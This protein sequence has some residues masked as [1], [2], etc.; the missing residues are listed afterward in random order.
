MLNIRNK[1]EV[2]CF[3]CEL[4]REIRQGAAGPGP[5]GPAVDRGPH[6]SGGRT[7]PSDPL[8]SSSSCCSTSFPSGLF[9][10]CGT[11]HTAVQIASRSPT[12]A[13]FMARI[14]QSCIRTNVL[15]PSVGHV[16]PSYG[17]YPP[18]A[19]ARRGMYVEPSPARPTGLANARGPRNWQKHALQQFPSHNI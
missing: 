15:A 12:T 11:L 4:Y 7:H 18:P 9:G 16:P 3:L 17:P 5:L 1:Q 10:I 8:C 2:L 13:L 19:L 14:Q 6:R